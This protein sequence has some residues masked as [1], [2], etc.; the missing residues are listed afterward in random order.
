MRDHSLPIASPEAL[1]IP[2]QAILQFLREMQEC[3]F[4]LHSYIVMRHGTIAAEGSIDPFTA[5]RTHRIGQTRSVNIIRLVVRDSVE[6]RIL[7][8]HERKRAL[9][10]DLVEESTGALSSLSVDDFKFL[11]GR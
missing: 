5:D 2:S 6:E 7:A 11:L 4:P 10:N 9:F 8:L 1:G 3:Q